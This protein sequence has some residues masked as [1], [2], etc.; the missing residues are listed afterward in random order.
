MFVSDGFFDVSGKVFVITGGDKGLGFETAK[1]LVREL[2]ADMT[3]FAFPFFPF[4]HDINGPE[5]CHMAKVLSNSLDLD[6]GSL[7]TAGKDPDPFTARGPVRGL[8]RYILYTFV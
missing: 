8:F 7:L 5:H 6:L 1:R 4:S 2:T 3:V